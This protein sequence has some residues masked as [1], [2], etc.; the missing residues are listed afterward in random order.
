M[1]RVKVTPAKP[2]LAPQRPHVLEADGDRRVDPYYWLRDKQNPEVIGYLEAENAYADAVMSGAADLQDVLYREVVGRVQETD[3]SAPVFFKGWWSYTR[4]V[5]GLDYEIYCRRRGSM[6]A[7]EEVIL[8]ANELAKGLEYFELGYVE[9]SPDENVLAYAV[10]VNGSELHELRFR[11]LGTGRD[12]GDAISGVYYGAA[13]AA[14]NRTFFYVRP[15]STMRPYQVWRHRLGDETAQDKLVLQEDD[16]RFELNVELSKSERYIVMSSSS[17]VTSECRFLRSGAPDEEP[18]LIEARRAEIDRRPGRP[19]PD[20]DQRRG[21]QLQADGGA[22]GEPGPFLV[23]GCR[24]GASWRAPQL[25]R[26]PPAPRRTGPAVG[27]P[28]AARG[29]RFLNRPAPRGRAA[30]L[31]LH[32]VPRGESGLREQGDALFLHLAHRTVVGGRLRHGDPDAH[33]REGTA[34]AWR[35]QP[36]RLQHGAAMGDVP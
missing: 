11:D 4:T 33:D 34:R 25:H 31:G 30:G 13:W 17:Q 5:E 29:A 10:D 21:Y 26:R 28:A 7:P 36:R 19:I 1:E 24:P 9:R 23:D 16:E 3:Y 14:D 22:G 6:E 35:L 15:D 27:R 20:P 12:L 18:V 8:D 32:G 2:P